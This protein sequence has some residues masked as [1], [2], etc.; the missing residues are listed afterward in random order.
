MSMFIKVQILSNQ[1]NS[2]YVN[3]D[4]YITSL[5]STLYSCI[6]DQDYKEAITLF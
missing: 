6:H 1:F 4:L 5:S 2:Y 3:N